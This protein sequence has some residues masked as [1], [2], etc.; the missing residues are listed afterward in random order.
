MKKG[1]LS[2][3]IFLAASTSTAAGLEV[4]VKSVRLDAAGENLIVDV[5]HGGGCAKHKYELQIGA[6][7]ERFPVSCSAT[8]VDKGDPDPCEAMIYATAVFP[9]A[10]YKLNESYYSRADLNF[11]TYDSSGKKKTISVTLPEA[12]GGGGGQPGGSG[13]SI[14]SCVTHTGSKLTI[15]ASAKSATLVATDGQTHKMRITNVDSL[16]LES[17]PPI[18]ENIYSLNDGRKIETWFRGDEKSGHGKFIRVDGSRSPEF[19]CKEN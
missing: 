19:T 13:S 1:I 4:G 12:N 16:T 15:D 14:V 3:A 17:N 11:E 10:K 8:V 18:S 7:M 2:L 6:C 5:F 9:L